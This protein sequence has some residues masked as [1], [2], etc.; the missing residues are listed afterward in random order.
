LDVTAAR[1]L[2]KND[3]LSSLDR[4][5]GTAKSESDGPEAAQLSRQLGKN[6]RKVPGICQQT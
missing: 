5:A 6:A 1:I 3:F 2:I 4:G